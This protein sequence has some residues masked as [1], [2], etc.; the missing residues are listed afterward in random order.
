MDKISETCAWLDVNGIS[1]TMVRHTAVFTIDEMDQLGLADT[2]H[3]CKNLFL[4][5]AKGKRHF[6]VSVAGHKTVDLRAL[7]EQLG[8]V[9]LSFAS[10]ARLADYLNLTKGAVTPLGMYYDKDAA[11]EFVFDAD[12]IREGT[13]G[14]HPGENTATVYLEAEDLLRLI[15]ANGNSVQVLPI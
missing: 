7:G 12:L 8:G 2:G 10:E 15:R 9:R 13:V 11:V 3:I 4:R 14:V 1:Y 5:D 6:L